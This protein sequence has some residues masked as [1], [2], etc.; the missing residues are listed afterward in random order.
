MTLNWLS[1]LSQLLRLHLCGVL[2]GA[3]V[4]TPGIVQVGQVLYQLNSPTPKM[5]F[6]EY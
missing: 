3:G 4:G 2:C 5:S 1:D 6:V